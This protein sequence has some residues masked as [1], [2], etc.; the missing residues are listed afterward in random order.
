MGASASAYDGSADDIP[1][2]IQDL[3]EQ[4]EEIKRNIAVKDAQ[5]IHGQ[6]IHNWKDHTHLIA[7]LSE[8]TK[9]QLI[10]AAKI[11]PEYDGEG[12]NVND[13]V[14]DSQATKALEQKLYTM[15]GRTPYAEFMKDC[16]MCPEAVDVELLT[17]TLNYLGTNETLLAEIICTLAPDELQRATS[18]FEAESGV[19]LLDKVV[20]KTKN[21]SAFQKF[22]SRILTV[23]RNFDDDSSR[24]ETDVFPLVE[25]LHNSGLGCDNPRDDDRIFEIL[26]KASRTECQQIETVFFSTYNVDFHDALREKYKGSIA[27]ALIMWTEGHINDAIAQRIEHNLRS[28]VS[29]STDAA[30]ELSKSQVDIRLLSHIFARYDHPQL[31]LIRESY[32]KIFG[33]DLVVET[34]SKLTG[35][36]NRGMRASQELNCCI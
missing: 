4:C 22:I 35:K 31:V 16:V 14:S 1:K 8:R 19:K 3:F 18:L 9:N 25:D 32:Q 10:T 28:S 20:K 27:Q 23:P 17:D 15:L 24:A 33:K 2:D 12:L 6:S 13:G 21:G 7:L 26:G 11:F 5:F 36:C 34:E 29:K 30:D